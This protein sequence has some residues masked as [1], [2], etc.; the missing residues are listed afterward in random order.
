MDIKLLPIPTLAPDLTSSYLD[1]PSTHHGVAF[2]SRAT[3]RRR[4]APHSSDVHESDRLRLS[5]RNVAETDDKEAV[6]S[7]SKPEGFP[8]RTC[9]MIVIHYHTVLVGGHAA[10]AEA[11]R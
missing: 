7:S 6:T 2:E 3:S 11:S 5:K 9:F 1:I 8:N 4:S 10:W